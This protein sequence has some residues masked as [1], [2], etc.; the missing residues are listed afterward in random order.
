MKFF[1]RYFNIISFTLLIFVVILFLQNLKY[2]PDFDL[3]DKK[4][5]YLGRFLLNYNIAKNI[6]TLNTDPVKYEKKILD[7]LAI[8]PKSLPEDKR[9]NYAKSIKLKIELAKKGMQLA[10]ED[11]KGNYFEIMK[12]DNTIRLIDLV[13]FARDDEGYISPLDE[14]G[15]E[16]EEVYGLSKLD[17]DFTAPE[18]KDLLINQLAQ[19]ME[20]YIDYN[21]IRAMFDVLHKEIK[22][23]LVLS[24]ITYKN[25]AGVYMLFSQQDLIRKNNFHLIFL[26]FAFIIT[27]LKDKKYNA[28]K[29]NYT[30]NTSL[31]TMTN[32]YIREFLCLAFI[33][34][35]LPVSLL[36]AANLGGKGFSFKAPVLTIPEDYELS[37]TK[38]LGAN[39][40]EGAE[41]ITGYDVI[42]YATFFA[43]DT[44]Y[45]AGRSDVLIMSYKPQI[46]EYKT[47]FIK[48]VVLD[49]LR[50][51]LVAVAVAFIASVFN[52]RWVVLL[53]T[54]A[55]AILFLNAY[56][57]NSIFDPFSWP[58]STSIVKGVR[59]LKGGR[60]SFNRAMTILSS[61]TV[62]IYLL[63]LLVL[64]KKKALV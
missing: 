33:T 41:R 26:A 4:D 56:N 38:S 55:L 12:I 23:K 11:F 21:Y 17:Y 46:Q 42:D 51:L 25:F 47:I 32:K 24:E 52:K 34:V 31:F 57:L 22:D 45:A 18:N 43:D 37:D 2:I 53:F 36:L 13:Q 10:N 5:T 30:M 19:D 64:K 54:T 61:Y 9:E 60:L 14:Y 28:P 48:A 59:V 8:I 3:D 1:K 20:C 50:I 35:I 6:E 27:V 62:V 16:L 58:V 49:L 7:D 44:T 29:L 63:N 39:A 15:S 40:K